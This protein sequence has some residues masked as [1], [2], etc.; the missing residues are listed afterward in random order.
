MIQYL[1]G[2]KELLDRYRNAPPSAKALVDAVMDARRLGMRSAAL[3]EAFL[4]TAA[5]GYLTDADWDLQPPD[6]LQQGLAYTAQPVKGVRGPLAPSA[7]DPPPAARPAP[8]AGGN[9]SWLTT[10]T[11]KAAACAARRS[12]R[13]P[14]GMP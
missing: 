8:A 5:P 4:E 13:H 9:G 12:L 14:S 7:P 6:W 11:S 3:P 1:A 2:A 10:W